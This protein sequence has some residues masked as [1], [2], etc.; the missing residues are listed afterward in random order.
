M[1]VAG[2]T[3]REAI[4][5]E[6]TVCTKPSDQVMLNGAV[7]VS[8]AVMVVEPPAQIAALPLTLAVGCGL[9]VTFT[10]LPLPQPLCVTVMPSWVV[11]DAP[12]VKVIAFVPAPPVMAPLVMVQR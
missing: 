4:V 3:L 5:P 7:P 11:P 10:E 8:E 12:A 6:L 9:T 2:L 1:L